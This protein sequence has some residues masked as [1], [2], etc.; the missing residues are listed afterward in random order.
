MGYLKK[1]LAQS[2][3][4]EINKGRGRGG[5]CKKG[6]AFLVSDKRKEGDGGNRTAK[7]KKAGRLQVSAVSLDNVPTHV[8]C[9]VH[10]HVHAGV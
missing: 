10:T 5:A 2:E 9:L 4:R 1:R 8:P 6:L 3:I 7:K